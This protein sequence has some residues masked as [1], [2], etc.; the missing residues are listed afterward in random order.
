M[1]QIVTLQS[2]LDVQSGENE[3]GTW[4]RGGMVCESLDG[5]QRQMAFKVQ[6]KQ[7]LDDLQQIPVGS[8]IEVTFQ[9][10]SR[11]FND[12]WYTDLVVSHIDTLKAN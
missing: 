4:Y 9:A 7:N 8:T 3:R 5:H 11:K 2:I 1:K 12:K 6:G 10:F